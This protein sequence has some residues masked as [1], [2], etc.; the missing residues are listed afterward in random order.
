MSNR[1]PSDIG[2]S[3]DVPS[4]EEALDIMEGRLPAEDVRETDE[5]ALAIARGLLTEPDEASARGG[6]RMVELFT[7]QPWMR[8]AAAM[9]FG[10]AVA[11]LM[12]PAGED[13][14]RGAG[15]ASANVI[16][17]DT[18][19]GVDPAY[20]PTIELGDEPYVTLVAYPDF[21]ETQRL[22]VHVERVAAP[23]EPLDAAIRAD[24]WV[25]VFEATTG[26]GNA[27]SVV[28]NVSA[29]ALQP[30]LHRLRIE[31]ASAAG[32]APELVNLFLVAR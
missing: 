17:L 4:D 31:S 19:R 25:T 29:D 14:G 12:S 8:M 28:V 30:G 20:V 1:Y 10:V 23:G 27:D 21:R 13:G 18:V 3:L 16:Y 5:A 15:L 11:T 22:G 9:V 32:A 26:V 7:R 2:R 6:G 24:Q